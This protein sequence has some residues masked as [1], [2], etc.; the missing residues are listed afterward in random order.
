MFPA[1][2]QG[3]DTV[4]TTL[5][6]EFLAML[7]T[8]PEAL[9]S[10]LP[11]AIFSSDANEVQLSLSQ[12]LTPASCLSLLLEQL[13]APLRA[14]LNTLL[15]LCGI[16][17]LCALWNCV[18]TQLKSLTLT[19]ILQ[20]L[21]RTAIF[22]LTSTHAMT[23]LSVVSAFY[24][25]LQALNTA[26]LPLMGVMYAMGGNI[27]TA[28][29]NQTTLTLSLSLVELIGG[30]TV[31][32]LFA[33]CLCFALLGAFESTVGAR[34]AVLTGKLKKWY[35]TAL[36]L[37][38][39][40]LSALLG[41]Q[42]TLQARTDSLTFRTVRFAVANSIPVVG[43][44]V[45]EMLR[46]AASGVEWLRGLT[47]MSGIVLLFLLLLPTLLSLWLTRW[48]FSLSADVAAWLGCPAEGKLL[49]EISSLYGYLLA[50]VAV[51]VLCFLFALL[52]LLKCTAAT[53]G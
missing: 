19:P 46:T 4:V 11:D 8:L 49:T 9:Q 22:V 6:D 24:Q 3:A 23:Q 32:P 1:C 27:G 44:G 14:Q 17:L 35:T 16:L 10:S 15:G 38:M 33:L 41:A 21:C 53:G 5:P 37:V 18:S 7:D 51:S 39:M 34:M 50:V 13:S 40:L 31:L 25:D 47:G 30:Q 20:L 36:S 52:L 26:F 48:M 45:A 28:A 43:G 2:A 12:L 42:H 29:A